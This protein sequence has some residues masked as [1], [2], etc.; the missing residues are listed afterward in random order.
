MSDELYRDMGYTSAPINVMARVSGL[1]S[2][3]ET[4]HQHAY[5]V[6]G[7]IQTWASIWRDAEGQIWIRPHSDDCE[8][9]L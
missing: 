3:C 5:V 9:K 2:I 6:N 1:L 4:C 7:V 8:A